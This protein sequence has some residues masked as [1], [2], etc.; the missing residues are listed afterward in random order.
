MSSVDVSPQPQQP[1][2]A[3]APPIDERLAALIAEDLAES[4][5]DPQY[6]PWER[7]GWQ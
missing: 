6:G 4:L 1:P 3:D 2:S 7:E 5:I